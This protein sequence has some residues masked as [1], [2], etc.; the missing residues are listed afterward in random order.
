MNLD[1]AGIMYISVEHIDNGN[2]SGSIMNLHMKERVPF[3]S[4]A[5]M[6]LKIDRI[7]EEIQGAGDDKSICIG[8]LHPEEFPISMQNLYFFLIHIRYTQHSSW[9]GTLKCSARQEEVCFKSVLDL[10]WKMIE[11][12]QILSYDTT[13]IHS[14]EGR[15]N[16]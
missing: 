12:M 1:M 9:Q 15:D 7:R 4:L 13:F 3:G 11:I 2:V 16:I 14:G 6:V 8:P 5:E 10:M